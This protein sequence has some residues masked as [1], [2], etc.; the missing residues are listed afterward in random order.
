M[1]DKIIG[2]RK[3]KQVAVKV[4]KQKSAYAAVLKKGLLPKFD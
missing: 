2:G 3:A 1:I 4:A